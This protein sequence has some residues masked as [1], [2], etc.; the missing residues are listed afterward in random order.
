MLDGRKQSNVL[1][2]KLWNL[3]KFLGGISGILVH[4]IS[5]LYYV[6]GIGL[7]CIKLMEKCVGEKARKSN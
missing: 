3:L 5:N 1:H 7:M 4:L 2:S 6:Q